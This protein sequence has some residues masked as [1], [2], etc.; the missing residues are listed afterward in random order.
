MCIK[1]FVLTT[2]ITDRWCSLFKPSVIIKFASNLKL[3][4]SSD[5]KNKLIS[6]FKVELSKI[7]MALQVLILY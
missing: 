7:G 3:M 5:S 4:G 1:A 6:L 2:D